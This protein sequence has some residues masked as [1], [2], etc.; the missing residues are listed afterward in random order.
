M[1][2]PKD[3][4]DDHSYPNDNRNPFE[5]CTELESPV[6]RLDNFNPHALLI[7]CQLSNTSTLGVELGFDFNVIEPAHAERLAAQ[8]EHLLRQTCK[9]GHKKVSEVDMTRP[10]DLA[11]L[12]KWN[13][14]VAIAVQ[15]TV[16]D[17]IAEAVNL[18]LEAQ[19]ICA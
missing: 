1:Q 16:Q 11:E 4:Q 9:S 3:V 7:E 8:F 19:A 10:K 5:S 2:P 6:G 18:W 13:A 15:M 14:H 12:W 17:R